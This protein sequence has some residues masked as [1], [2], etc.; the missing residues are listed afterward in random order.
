[1]LLLR[2]PG[3]M[4]I[5]NSTYPNGRGPSNLCVVSGLR[6]SL[7]VSLSS[8]FGI[9]TPLSLGTDVLRSLYG[10]KYL[11]LS[12]NRTAAASVK[13][14]TMKIQVTLLMLLPALPLAV[15]QEHLFLPIL[16]SG[17]TLVA[18]LVLLCF[19]GTG[20]AK[21]LAARLHIE[22][23]PEE[24]STL[25]STLETKHMLPIYGAFAAQIV[26]E[27]LSVCLLLPS[28]GA[29]LGIRPVFALFVLLYFLSRTPF[30]PQGVGVTESAGFLVLVS[31][32]VPRTQAGA[33]LTLWG[34][35]RI[36][37]PLILA[38]FAYISLRTSRPEQNS[39][40]GREAHRGLGFPDFVIP[41]S[42]R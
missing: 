8:L 26:F 18:I 28:V 38:G 7:A 25:D 22:N 15:G 9:L 31:L 35:L 40:A 36:L 10:R 41:I 3:Q 34:F 12:L 19:M 16:L 37:C 24:I 23:L 42:N 2:R 17:C 20:E 29:H 33:F 1:M 21:K 4:N 14:R 32:E 6:K 13:A 5:C 30:T 27:W 11:S 39:A